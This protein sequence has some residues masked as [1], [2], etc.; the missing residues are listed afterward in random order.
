MKEFLVSYELNGRVYHSNVITDTSASAMYWIMNAF[1][2][3]QKIY[4]IREVA[5]MYN[6]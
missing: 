3:A 5:V 4:V 2:E 1:P 6:Y